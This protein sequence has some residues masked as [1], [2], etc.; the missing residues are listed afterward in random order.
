MDV[1]VPHVAPSRAALRPL[2]AALA[3]L[4]TVGLLAVFGAPSPASAKTEPLPPTP[5]GSVRM[6]TANLLSG[7]P[8]GKFEADL[9]SVFLNQP[10]FVTFNEVPYRADA[11]LAPPGYAIWRTPGQYEGANP[12]VW[13]TDRWTAIAQGTANITNRWGKTKKQSVHWG[14]RYANWVTLQGIDGRVV[15]VIATHFPPKSEITEGLT[16]V[17]V[18]ALGNLVDSLR[19]SGP[20]LV[21]GD[22]NFHYANPKEYPRD[23][24]T[25]RA[26]TPIYDVLGYYLPTGDHYGATIDYILLSDTAQVATNALY[27][28]ELNS[29]HD[30]V[31]ADLTLTGAPPSGVLTFGPGTV[32]NDPNGG[33]DN[34]RAV[35]DLMI[36]AIDGAPKGAGIHLET[37]SLLDKKI[38]NALLRAKDRGVKVQ[39]LSRRT[40]SSKVEKSLYSALGKRIFKR[41]WGVACP[42]AC[43]RMESR[44]ALPTARLLVS[45]SGITP[46]VRIDVDAP[47][48]FNSAKSPMTGT[49]TTS[50]GKYDGAF[51]AFL[52]LVGR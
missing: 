39:F 24:L 45:K 23:L 22:L 7:Q 40:P 13:R 31:T 20:V 50:Q 35:L 15:S 34:K 3:T 37:V 47:L 28:T 5:L 52:K 44:R 17:A 25:A 51:K 11:Q 9:A 41:Q 42:K 38:R 1:P 30:A 26:L 12:V 6:T 10:D 19:A 46:A 8:Q 21:G 27:T 48:S 14:V 49:I 18:N 16:P 33:L 43:Q 2:A 4:L 32:V 29:D 36:R